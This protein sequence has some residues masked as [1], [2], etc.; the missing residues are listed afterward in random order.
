MFE[1][2]RVN[3]FQSLRKVEISLGRLTVIVGASSSGKT[4]LIRALRILTSNSR[5][6][7]YVSYGQ[8]I[9]S[10]MARTDA[11]IITIE[12][13]ESH[14]V[15][16]LVTGQEIPV[17]KT[18][19]KLGG[20]VPEQVSAALG[21]KPFVDGVSLNFANQFDRPY[22]LTET[23]STVAATLGA[24][25]N[26][27]VLF[28]AVR[29]ANRRRLALQAQLKVRQ[30]DLTMLIAQVEKFSD[31]AE[32]TTLCKAVEL[33]VVDVKELKAKIDRLQRGIAVAE[34]AERVLAQHQALPPVPSLNGLKEAYR[35]LTMCRDKM[36]AW[37][38]AKQAFE[39]AS[40]G[41]AQW[42]QTEKDAHA[43]LH[44]ALIDAG[45]CPTCGQ[46]I[47]RNL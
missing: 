32:R 13:G 46:V 37:L 6:S 47:W 14:G 33:E 31:L 43:A 17:E 24:L 20:D 9:A 2:I 10:V 40:K 8:K 36:D 21:M 27:N 39:G 18:F 3:N 5:G 38:F 11:G 28:A 35:R 44:Q 15:Y 23:G 19:T 41:L 34:E 16:R 1:E 12:R 22:L 42:Q 7:T 30:H 26:V 4:A 29:E 25:T 45:S